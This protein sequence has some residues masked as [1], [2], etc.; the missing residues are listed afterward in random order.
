MAGR[1]NKDAPAAVDAAPGHGKGAV[2]PMR[3]TD[4]PSAE[5]ALTEA[6]RQGQTSVQVSCPEAACDEPLVLVDLR[7]EQLGSG[8]TDRPSGD[9]ALCDEIGEPIDRCPG[10]LE[11]LA[12]D[13]VI[14]RDRHGRCAQALA[15]EAGDDRAGRGRALLAALGSDDI[16]TAAALL[17]A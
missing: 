9:I 10:C 5:M 4:Y 1:E 7:A 11:Q 12:T 16:P 13:Q 17:V 2:T 15:D 8:A 6:V 14:L 3:I